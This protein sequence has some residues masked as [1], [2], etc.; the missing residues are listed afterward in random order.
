MQVPCSLRKGTLPP[1][2]PWRN[3]KPLGSAIKICISPASGAFLRPG[4]FCARAASVAVVAPTKSADTTLGKTLTESAAPGQDLEALAEAAGVQKEVRC[5]PT[6]LGRGLLATR[7]LGPQTIVS[8]PLHNALVITD[9]PLSGISVFG[10]RCL[11]EWQRQH[12]TLPQQLQDFVTG[13]QGGGQVGRQGGRLAC[14]L[15]C[16][17]MGS[18]G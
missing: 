10:D 9:Q 12:A 6:P 1:A 16:L 4:G 5:G 17:G 14:Y 18:S 7:A 2:V 11:A 8:V 15:A 3:P 13:G